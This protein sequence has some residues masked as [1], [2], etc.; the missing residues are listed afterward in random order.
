MDLTQDEVTQILKW[1]EDSNFDEL[2]LMMGETKLVVKKRRDGSPVAE[3]V[4]AKATNQA[5]VPEK[6]VMEVEKGKPLCTAYEMEGR[7]GA[8]LEEGLSA[9]RSPMLGT[10][11][12]RPAPGAPPY[13]E[14]GSFVKEGDTVCLIEVMKVFNAVKAG[15]IGFIAKIFPET[16]QLVEYGQT[17]FFVSPDDRV[18]KKE[19]HEKNFQAPGG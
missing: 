14:V 19:K 16:G 9:I 5:V 12:R 11:Y 10:F 1:I 7:S 2:S 4:V 6:A 15:V 3:E 18:Q 13:V 8:I 17:L